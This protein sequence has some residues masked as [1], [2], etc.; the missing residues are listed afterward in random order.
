MS[1]GLT[2]LTG[3]A[4]AATGLG[5][6]VLQLTSAQERAQAAA[7]QMRRDYADTNARFIAARNMF[8]N[9]NLD[10]L[11]SEIAAQEDLIRRMTGRFSEQSTAFKSAGRVSRM[12]A[13]GGA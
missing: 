4:A 12:S 8:R 2:G 9:T 3:A 11:G 5:L 6:L 13:E 10:F 7:E 1:T